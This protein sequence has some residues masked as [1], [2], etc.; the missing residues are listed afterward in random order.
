MEDRRSLTHSDVAYINVYR[1]I[2]MFAIGVLTAIIAF[3]VDTGIMKLASF[4]FGVLS[5]SIN[6]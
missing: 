6:R 2:I 3:L 1:W 4:K 5:E